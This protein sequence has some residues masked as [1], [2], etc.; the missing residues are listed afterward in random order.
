MTIKSI[1]ER[2]LPDKIEIDLTGPDGNAFAL[3]GYVRKLTKPLGLDHKKI[4]EEMMGA[5]DYDALLEV[6]ESYFGEYV[7]L[8]R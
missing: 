3:M 8:F 1:K 5:E 4:I 2:K 6:F 7:V